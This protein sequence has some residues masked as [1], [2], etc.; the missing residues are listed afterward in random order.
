[1]VGFLPTGASAV[2]V[3]WS[4]RLDR[5]D[6]VRAAGVRA[7]RDDLL[8]LAPMAERVI[9]GLS[10]MDQLLPASYRTVSLRHWHDGTLVLLG[11]AA[12][13]L[14]PQLGQGA[15]LALMDAAALA[16]AASLDAFEAARRPQA[17]FY[18]FGARALNA[19]F[20]NDHDA[21]AWPRDHLMATGV[22]PA[23]GSRRRA[24]EVLAGV[25]NGPFTSHPYVK[26]LLL[27]FV[28][29]TGCS[30]SAEHGLPGQRVRLAG[31]GQAAR[32]SGSC[33]ARCRSRRRT[34]P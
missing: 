13:A 9:A 24:L 33:A 5:I 18:G 14:S 16:D 20:Q 21:F 11:D 25:A 6:A 31:D 2:S 19:V 1:M 12:H 27:A 34:W 17:R 30:G 4:V 32:R 10:S 29:V 28:Q 8:S 3:F 23:V 15:N 26:R 22:A 7:F